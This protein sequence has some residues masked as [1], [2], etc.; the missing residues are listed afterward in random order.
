LC[1]ILVFCDRRRGRAVGIVAAFWG[2]SGNSKVTIEGAVAL[3]IGAQCFSLAGW[4]R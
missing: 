3:A 4:W 2:L 1:R